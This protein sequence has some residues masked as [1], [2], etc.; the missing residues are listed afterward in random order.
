MQTKNTSKFDV[1]I[2]FYK[3]LLSKLLLKGSSHMGIK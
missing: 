2:Y 3:C 1:L